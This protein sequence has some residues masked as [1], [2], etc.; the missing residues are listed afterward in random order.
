MSSS[1]TENGLETDLHHNAI[2]AM[3]LKT[4]ISYDGHFKLTHGDTL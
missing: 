4:R 3:L 1:G 2:E